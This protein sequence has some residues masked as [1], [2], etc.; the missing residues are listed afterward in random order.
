MSKILIS[1]IVPVRDAEEFIHG[2]L[3][4]LLAM[5][6]PEQRLELIVVDNGSL[7]ATASIAGAYPVTLLEESIPGSTAARNTGIAAARGEII[8]F[9][10]ADCRVR[11]NWA[12]QLEASFNDPDIDAVIGFAEGINDNLH[13]EFVQRRWE[14]SRF[15]REGD[16]FVLKQSGIDTRNCAL[17][18]RVFDELGC[19]DGAVEYCG[20]LEMSIRLNRAGYH[21]AFNPDLV[22]GHKNPTSFRVV[23]AKSTKQLEHVLALRAGLPADVDWGQI[24]FAASAFYGVAELNLN[25]PLRCVLLAVL[26]VIR[27]TLFGVTQLLLSLQVDRQ[28]AYKLYKVFFGLSYDIAILAAKANKAP[29]AG[30]G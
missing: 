29:A 26:R 20:D 16:R 10:D 1:V 2:C 24:P 23:L 15:R 8:A 18:R 27:A 21:T 19:F 4:S 17:R 5:D 30:A 28:C 13:A 3:E 9:T 6:Y 12:R 25:G 22:V 7:D 11:P 14:E